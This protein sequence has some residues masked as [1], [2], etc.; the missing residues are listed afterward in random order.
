MDRCK[1]VRVVV[2]AIRLKPALLNNTNPLKTAVSFTP[3]D[4]S[5]NFIL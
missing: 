4:I 3:M 5:L 2:K 1:A